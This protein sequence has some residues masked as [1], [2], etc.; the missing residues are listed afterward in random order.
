MTKSTITFL[1]AAL[2]FYSSGC[3]QGGGH[4]HDGHGHGHGGHSDKPAPSEVTLSRIA[5]QQ[6]GLRIEAV[7][8]H[9]LKPQFSVPARVAFNEE[10]TAHVGTLVQGRVSKMHVHLGRT[11]TNGAPLFDIV[12]PQLGQ[13]QNSFLQALAVEAAAKPAEVLARNDAGVAQAESEVKAAEALLALAKN[14]AAVVQAQGKV[15]A[16]KPTLVRA[17]ELYD[18]GQKLVA[19]GAL[20]VGEL[21]RRQAAKQ[22]AAAEVRAAEAALDQAKAQQTR[23]TAD[24]QAKLDAALA[25]HIAAKALLTKEI[26][27]TENALKA[28]S[29]AVATARNRL[30]LFGM[31]PAALDQLTSSRHLDPTY[32]VLAP[33]AGTVV[34]REVT[35]GENVSPDQ[36]HL[37]I[38]AD[39]SQVWVLMEVPPSHAG[40]V[41]RGMSVTLLDRDTGRKT[42]A[43]LDYISPTVDPETRTVQV[44][45]ELANS[46][47]RWR[48]GQFLTA[49]LPIGGKPLETLAVPDGAVQEVDGQPTVYVQPDA[50]KLTFK[51]RPVVAGKPIGGLRP[52]SGLEPRERV[53][54]N[55]SFLLKAEFGKAKAGHDHSH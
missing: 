16:T 30:K 7:K 8:M 45:V 47:G 25:G 4:S 26:G 40:K 50:T 49:Q 19:V 37:L 1:I 9:L 29:A 55:G 13:A 35:Q 20:A 24:A 6:N 43:V 17:T 15:D 2:A 36:P 34:E 18:S 33:R 12:S 11:V 41:Q 32:K 38:L 27:A 48:P 5:F 46:D 39:L 42:S 44:R 22:T 14:P 51:S 28:A 31:A 53:V 21:K 10:T 3:G 54:V 52:I 23:D